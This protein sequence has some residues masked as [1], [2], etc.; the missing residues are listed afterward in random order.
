MTCPAWE[1]ARGLL[2][3][4]G[5]QVGHPMPSSDRIMLSVT[6]TAR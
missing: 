3:G 4:V 1:T 5:W 6:D 2:T